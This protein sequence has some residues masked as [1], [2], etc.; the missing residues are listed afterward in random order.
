MVGWWEDAGEAP[1]TLRRA[2]TPAWSDGK[3]WKTPEFG[4]DRTPEFWRRINAGI[5]ISGLDE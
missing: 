3:A 1:A 4:Y 2:P 5:L